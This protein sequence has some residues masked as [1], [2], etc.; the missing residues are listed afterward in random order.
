MAVFFNAIHEKARSFDLKVYMYLLFTM[1]F[2]QRMMSDL[3]SEDL[4]VLMREANNSRYL[5]HF[6]G[7][8]IR[9]VC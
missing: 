8:L 2:K 7:T 9:E 1:H 6:Y 3:D 5:V 4:H